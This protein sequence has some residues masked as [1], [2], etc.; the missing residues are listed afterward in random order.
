M[1]ETLLE[2]IHA[3]ALAGKSY[4]F[5]VAVS[6]F[7]GAG[8]SVLTVKLKAVL[9]DAEIISIDAFVVDHLSR[10]SEDWEGFDRE[11]LL[12]EVLV[13]A[14]KKQTIHYGIYNWEINTVMETKTIQPTTFLIVEGCSIFHPDLMS[15][16]DYSIWIDVPLEEATRRGIQRDRM[17]GADWDDNWHSI[18]MPNENDFFAK[19]RPDMKADFI[20]H[21]D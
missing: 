4:P 9:D 1:F 7:G 6:G 15:Y 13:P 11:R 8:K 20:Y 21:P 17:Q 3:K 10:R 12:K 14:K 19:Y 2:V 16:Y 5:I 18:W